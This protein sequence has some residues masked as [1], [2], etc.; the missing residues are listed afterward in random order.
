M[1][2]ESVEE[3]EE[4]LKKVQGRLDGLERAARNMEGELGEMRTRIA[5]I[6][7]SV[8]E[9]LLIFR[10]LSDRL[11]AQARAGQRARAGEGVVGGGRVSGRN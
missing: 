8:Q 10:G 7:S 1:A 3:L 6:E 9:M 5:S 2:P 11:E 4:A